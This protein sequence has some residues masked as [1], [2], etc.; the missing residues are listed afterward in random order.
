MP[1]ATDKVAEALPSKD[2]VKAEVAAAAK[3]SFQSLRALAAGGVGGIC[4]VVVGHPFDLVKVRLQTAEKG[5]YT[6]AMDVVRKT[7]AKE[8]MARVSLLIIGGRG[9]ADGLLGTVC[10]CVCAAGGR[11]ANV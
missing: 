3:G 9:G 6:G 7:I 2:E 4:A 1:S 5:V 8:G 10:R 11:D